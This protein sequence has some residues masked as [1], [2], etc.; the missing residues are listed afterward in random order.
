RCCLPVRRGWDSVP[1]PVSGEGRR[2]VQSSCLPL[3]RTHQLPAFADWA[4]VV[5]AAESGSTMP[6]SFLLRASQMWPHVGTASLLQ[7]GFVASS[8]RTSVVTH[9]RPSTAKEEVF[10]ACSL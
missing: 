2:N 3:L 10:N 4:R 6:V 8:T 5:G 1:R 9:R 7:R